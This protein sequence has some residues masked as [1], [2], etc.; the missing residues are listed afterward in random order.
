[1]I[2]IEPGDLCDPRVIDLIAAH[3]TR[4]R[5][6]TTPG[7]AH[8]LDLDRLRSSSIRFFA[9]FDDDKL[10]GIAALQA[11]SAVQG[12]VKSMHTVESWRRRGVGSALLQHVINVA[13]S[14]GFH[15]L[16]LETGSW[17][18]F[19]PART[20]YRRRGFEACGPFGDYVADPNS[21][22]MTLSLNGEPQGVVEP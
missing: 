12:E 21:V 2:R 5:A 19:A 10:T 9:A 18:Y 17:P 15:R 14:E 13:R 3:V 1:M 11:L 8:A 6:E 4:A 16:S 20:F 7:S 22:F